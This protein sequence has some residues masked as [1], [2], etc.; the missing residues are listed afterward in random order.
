MRLI[1]SYKGFDDIIH[2]VDIHIDI[3]N[4][5][6]AHEAMLPKYTD[7]QMHNMLAYLETLK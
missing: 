2:R 5:I 7:A 3:D 1:D 4:P 6:A